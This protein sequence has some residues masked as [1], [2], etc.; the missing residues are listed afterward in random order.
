MCIRD[1]LYYMYRGI[2]ED[3]DLRY[4]ITIIPAKMLGME[5]NKTKGHYHPESYGELYIVL[6]GEAIY[7]LQKLDQEGEIEDVYMVE[8]Q[9][10]E[11]VYKRQ[12]IA[13]VKLHSLYNL[14][15]KT[16]C[17]RLFHRDNSVFTHLVYHF[18][19]QV[20]HLGILDV[21]KR[22]TFNSLY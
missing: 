4:D 18:G 16:E 14:F 6:E 22:Q 10:G 9:K 1:R 2:K 17:L 19:D 11:D 20:T 3:G 15:L 7:L 12:D 8:A 13:S 5:F 21:Y